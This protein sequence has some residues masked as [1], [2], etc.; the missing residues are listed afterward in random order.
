M[1]AI[2]TDQFAGEQGRQ[3]VGTVCYLLFD[4]PVLFL[5]RLPQ[6]P[7][8]DCFMGI[9]V[10]NPFR[11][12]LLYH[13]F[14]LVGTGAGAVLCDYAEINGVIQ[15]VFHRGI[16]PKFGVFADAFFSVVQFPVPAGRKD[17]FLV[18][19]RRNLAVGHA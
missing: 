6:F 1:P 7:V 13:G 5:N 14:V 3:R 19:H 4:Y 12:R 10:A 16:G 2:S 8:N 9:L 15:D 17:V 11:F 18:Q